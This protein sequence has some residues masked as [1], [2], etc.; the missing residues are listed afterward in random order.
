MNHHTPIPLSHII[1][2]FFVLKETCANINYCFAIGQQ[3]RD[4]NI[5]V[6][7]Y[8]K[9]IYGKKEITWNYYNNV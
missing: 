8:D 4:G 7:F 1:C 3:D 2:H 6:I 5:K 9:I